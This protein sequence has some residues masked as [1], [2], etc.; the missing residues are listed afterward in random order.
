MVAPALILLGV[1]KRFLWRID[2]PPLVGVRVGLGRRRPASSV[3]TGVP[4]CGRSPA[5]RPRIRSYRVTTSLAS[6]PHALELR[7]PGVRGCQTFEVLGV[8]CWPRVRRLGP[9]QLVTPCDGPWWASGAAVFWASV[10]PLAVLLALLGAE[11]RDTQ[12][13][14]LARVSMP[15]ESCRSAFSRVGMWLRLAWRIQGPLWGVF[16]VPVRGRALMS[17]A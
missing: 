16:P 12:S 15:D 17:A 13:A 1:S 4:R 8:S 3:V 2:V 14:L 11:R 6:G 7:C 10:T 5:Q 9:R